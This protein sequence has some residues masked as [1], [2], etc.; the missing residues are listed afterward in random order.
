MSNGMSGA[1]AILGE[2][3]GVVL[4][5]AGASALGRPV[6]VAAR[7]TS[8]VASLLQRQRLD[9]IRSQAS[10]AYGLV[11]GAAGEKDP[12]TSLASATPTRA[13]GMATEP[14]SSRVVNGADVQTDASGQMPFPWY[15]QL[16]K[17]GTVGQGTFSR[18]ICGASIVHAWPAEAGEGGD[19]SAAKELEEE[20]S[21]R[22]GLWVVS[23]AH[24]LTDPDGIYVIN[25]YVG[26][27]GAYQNVRAEDSFPV[28][29]EATP[30]AGG[31]WLELP[32]RDVQLFVHPL[33]DN[34]TNH[35]DV[36]LIRC[37]FPRGMQLPDSLYDAASRSVRWQSIARLPVS[38]LL[39][40]RGAVIGFGATSPGGGVNHVLQ[41]GAVRIEDGSVRQRIT[42][43]P[44]YTPLLNTWAT[45]PT[46]AQGE[47]VDTCQG[48]S[49]GPLFA[50]E[51]ESRGGRTVDVATVFAVTSWGISCGEPAYP[52]VYAKLAP[53][54]G[55]PQG[56]AA[57]ALP[58]SSPWRLGML[59]MINTLSPRRFPY[60]GGDEDVPTLLPPPIDELPKDDARDEGDA[61]VVSQEAAA[62]NVGR[63]LM[64]VLG[65]AAGFFVLRRVIVR[66]KRV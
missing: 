18:L 36:A 11:F 58:R 43:H 30:N 16:R 40:E 9:A 34:T 50:A 19:P 37:L 13:I 5:R 48:D 59:D 53:F 23:A 61:A 46:N 17:H 51:R 20:E 38:G 60:R 14:L 54:V 33:Y 32:A 28:Q 63:W 25:L 56:D 49:G 21:T 55:V 3:E 31:A 4:S 10:S 12:I 64:G 22:A 26:G 35:F 42:V 57:A 27:Q 2:T 62:G 47:A 41:F 24:C 52:G 8:T 39:P 15:A 1:Q 45:G 65:A 7:M 6:D 29:G 66:R 44:A